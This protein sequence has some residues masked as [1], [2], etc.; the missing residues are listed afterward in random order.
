MAS[1][2][3]LCF[4]LFAL[5]L[6]AA[7]VQVSVSLHHEYN[8]DNL[9]SL[10][11]PD[12]PPGH[13]CTAPAAF[14]GLYSAH[15][16]VFQGLH[17][18][19]IAAIWRSGGR[20]SPTAPKHGCTGQVW[21]SRNGPGTWRWYMADEP[22]RTGYLTPATGASYIE[23]PR[24]WPINRKDAGWLSAEG[25]LGLVAADGRWFSNPSA[26][27]FLGYGSGI[28]PKSRLR[29]DIR[30]E[31]KGNVYATS[32]PGW[33]YPSIVDVNGTK[34]SDGGAGDLVYKDG[35]GNTLNL[36]Q[37]SDEIRKRKG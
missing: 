25:V 12:L 34:Y 2:N 31:V 3:T 1:L 36:T 9:V 19:N 16:V 37:L 8:P 4:W 22:S 7:T 32:P 14:F 10:E 5:S 20:R 28:R 30:S 27:K 29:R 11:C 13:C 15:M 33:T 21:K 35:A 6:V 26:Q 18:W 23:M 17:A 24:R